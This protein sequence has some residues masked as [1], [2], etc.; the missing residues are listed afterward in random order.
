[1]TVRRRFLLGPSFARLIKRERG[2]LCQ[3]E[4]FFPEQQDRSSWVRLEENRGLLV[5]QTQ[6]PE[7]EVENQTEVPVAH[8]HAL[9]DVCTGE[10]DYTRTALPIGEGQALVDEIIRPHVRHLVTMESA[11]EEEA[12][13]FRPLGWFGPE[14]TADLRYTN[15]SIALRGLAEAS[16]IPLSDAALNSLIDTLEGRFP[17]QTRMAV[18]LTRAKQVPGT[19]AKARTSGETVK[20][21]LDEIEQAMMR[22]MET[23]I[24]S[25][26]TE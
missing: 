17:T 26:N 18:S 1:M 10:V 7:G 4:G 13:G 5:L 23:A 25:G 8:A 11:T 15:Q 6:G 9:L 21:N 16:E 22:E 3:V 19:R 2:G 24:Q 14:V 12:R 20:V